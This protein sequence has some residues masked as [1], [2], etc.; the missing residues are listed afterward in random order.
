MSAGCHVADGHTA[1][2]FSRMR[3]SDPKGD[4]GRAERQRQV[5]GAIASEA[6]DPSVL[7]R[8]GDQVSLLDA[9]VG[10][11]TVDDPHGI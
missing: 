10:A 8:P 4:I 5:I 3:Y 7:F 2:A 9:G 1:L 6:A 11:L